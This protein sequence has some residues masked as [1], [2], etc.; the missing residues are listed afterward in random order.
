MSRLLSRNWLFKHLFALVILG[1]FIYL[2]FW[3]LNRLEERRAYNAAT[4]AAL[5]QPPITLT[6]APVDAEALHFHKVRVSGD[7]DHAASVV[8]RNQR[9]EG[10]DGVHLLTPLRIVGSDQAVMIDRGWLPAGLRTPADLAPFAGASTVTVEGLAF[11]TQSRPDALLAPMDLPLPGAT[12]IDAWMR[13]DIEKMQ[14]QIAYPLLPLYVQQAADP[15]APATAPPYP[16]GVSLDE[17]PHLSYAIQ[18]FTFAG[19]LLIVYA[20]LLRQELKR[21]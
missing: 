19:L 5:D 7:F 14:Q 17:G 1:M 8:L 10:Q 11:R 3:Q 15:A 21:R 9:R 2:G 13:V 18:W 12:R 4:R 6:G 16:Q 20:A